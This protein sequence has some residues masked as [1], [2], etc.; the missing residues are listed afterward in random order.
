MRNA[1]SVAI[2]LM[3][4][5]C[6]AASVVW[7]EMA[8]YKQNEPGSFLL[9]A[10][11]P[12]IY[13]D[14]LIISTPSFFNVSVENVDASH[15]KL[16]FS[17]D[18]YGAYEN[19]VIAQKDSMVN[20]STTRFLHDDEYL[21]HYMF[22]DN[23]YLGPKEL[24]VEAN[25]GLYLAFACSDVIAYSSPEVAPVVY[26]WV[27]LIV[28]ENGNVIAA[29]SAADLDG[30]P[31]VVGGGAWDGNIPEPSGGLLFLLG[32]ATLGLRRKSPRRC[33]DFQP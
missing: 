9:Y 31:M 25:T 12:G 14:M 2:L 29:S 30:G 27:E 11:Y 6:N 32:A 17:H 21:L 28:D 24:T 10:E 7:N 15:F 5:F 13:G 20:A 19:W 22:D 16:T 4:S 33:A 26:G 23:R 18:P 8:A 3:C 1:L